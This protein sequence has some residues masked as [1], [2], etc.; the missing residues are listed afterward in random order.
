MKVI[1]IDAREPSS[2]VNSFKF[3]CSTPR[4]DKYSVVVVNLNFGDV[5]HDKLAIELKTMSD[6]FNSIV[7]GRLQEQC[8]G[9]A[10]NFRSAFVLVSDKNEDQLNER[11]LKACYTSAIGTFFRYNVPMFFCPEEMRSYIAL[12][13]FE[14][15]DKGM[16]PVKPTTKVIVREDEEMLR[17][18]M[19]FEGI[20]IH[21]ATLIKGKYESLRQIFESNPSIMS[22]I[23]GIGEKTANQF[24]ATINK[25]FNTKKRDDQV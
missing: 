11:Q 16:E 21:R 23:P 12:K 13:I 17:V 20:G 10:T 4:F 2:T 15:A 22:E 18:L 1:Q 7:D 9:M 3:L 14:N 19:S 8:F 24:F 6:L 25:R 5:V